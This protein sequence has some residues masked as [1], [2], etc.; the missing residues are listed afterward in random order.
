MQFGWLG[1]VLLNLMIYFY[2]D[3]YRS[4]GM[5]FLLGIMLWTSITFTAASNFVFTPFLLL[6]GFVCRDAGLH[7]REQLRKAHWKKFAGSGKVA[8]K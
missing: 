5:L 3:K 8:Q 4:Y 1:F 2:F 6:Y 7:E